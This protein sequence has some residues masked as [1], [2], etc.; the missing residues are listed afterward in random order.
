MNLERDANMILANALGVFSVLGNLVPKFDDS[1]CLFKANI[2][3]PR[4]G[5]NLGNDN[6]HM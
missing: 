2:S 1:G 3:F 5:R 4:F 6:L